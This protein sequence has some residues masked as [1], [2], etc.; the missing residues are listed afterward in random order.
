MNGLLGVLPSSQLQWS[1]EEEARQASG[2]RARSED[3]DTRLHSDA[4]PLP[5]MYKILS[6]THEFAWTNFEG[7]LDTAEHTPRIGVLAGECT[8]GEMFHLSQL[9]P[10]RKC[11]S[12]RAQLY[13]AVKG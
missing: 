7:V 3:T 13:C 9:Y 2:A 8:N 5:R 10:T 4:I 11:R 6:D 12:K 1:M